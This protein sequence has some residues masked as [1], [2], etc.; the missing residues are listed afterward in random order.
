MSTVAH[1]QEWPSFR[2]PSGSGVST[3][4]RPPV[5]WNVAS[6]ANVAWRTP[7]AGLG[8]SSPIVWGDRIYL[9]TAVSSAAASQQLVLGDSDRAGI[10][11]AKDVVPHEWRVMA[12]D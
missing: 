4:A 11:P 2:G 12:L 9:T 10:D 5:R 1:G 7:I 3:T 8:H 6:S